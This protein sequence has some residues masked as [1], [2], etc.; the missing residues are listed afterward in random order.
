M[1][2]LKL[3]NEVILDVVEHLNPSGTYAVIRTSRR[4][5]YLCRD[6]L[7]KYYIRHRKNKILCWTVLKGRPSLVRRICQL[8]VKEDSHF[9][10]FRSVLLHIAAIQGDSLM[11]RLLLAEGADPKSRDRLSRTPLYWALERKDEQISKDIFGTIK[12]LP[13]FL[14]D[15]DRKLSALHAASYFGYAKMIEYLITSGANVNARDKNGHTPLKHARDSLR[16]GR[17]AATT[18]RYGAYHNIVETTRVLVALGEDRMTAKQAAILYVS[19]SNRAKQNEHCIRI[20]RSWAQDG[21]ECVIAKLRQVYWPWS[22]MYA[23]RQQLLCYSGHEIG[24]NP[25]IYSLVR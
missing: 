19:T 12:T 10:Y 5:Y 13:N 11:V 14:V 6:K 16:K 2:F 4:L 9:E 8:R 7:L 22:D 23:D 17:W 25:F 15:L 21:F 1:A 18:D 20:G 24:G 3:P